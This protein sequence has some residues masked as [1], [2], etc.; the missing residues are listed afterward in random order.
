MSE[1]ETETTTESTETAS[2]PAP[3]RRK[4]KRQVVDG[5]AHIHAS[6]NNTIITITDRQG[7][8]LSWATAGGRCK[9]ARRDRRSNRTR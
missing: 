1:A 3:A 2:T 7:G 5:L 8:A 9:T 4:G 6:F